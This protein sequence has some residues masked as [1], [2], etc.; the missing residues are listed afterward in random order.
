MN[1]K[2]DISEV[3][4]K[5]QNI[6][7]SNP[8]ELIKSEFFSMMM[9]D[10]SSQSSIAEKLTP[11]H[12]DKMIDNDAKELDNKYK[13]NYLR[14]IL[15]LILVFLLGLIF[16]LIIIILKDKPDVLEKIIYSVGGAILGGIGGYGFGNKNSKKSSDDD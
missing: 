9:R 7:S 4:E 11:E 5:Q 2:T 14:L 15:G 8:P 1:N 13:L 3:D 6:P 16:V 10:M 12:I